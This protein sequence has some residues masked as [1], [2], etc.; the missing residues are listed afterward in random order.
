MALMVKATLH[1]AVVVAT[2]EYAVLVL[3]YVR[4]N[5]EDIISCMT[6]V[7]EWAS[8]RLVYVMQLRQERYAIRL[9]VR[10]SHQT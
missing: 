5:A 2:A 9:F 1:G 10:K 3:I 8:D 6:S 7:R 4:S